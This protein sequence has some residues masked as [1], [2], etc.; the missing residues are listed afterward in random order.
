M[1]NVCEGTS[2]NNGNFGQQRSFLKSYVKPGGKNFMNVLFC[3]DED[4]ETTI[5]SIVRSLLESLDI[6]AACWAK[7][8]DNS[9]IGHCKSIA[10]KRQLQDVVLAFY[11]FYALFSGLV[12]TI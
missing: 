3:L 10:E 9:E 7:I 4:D 12:Q 8:F 5:K 2:E 6:D 1:L 11:F